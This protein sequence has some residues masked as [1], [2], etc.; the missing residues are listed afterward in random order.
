M[1]IPY[2]F[3]GIPNGE[4]IPLNYLDDNFTY[5][6]TQ[7]DSIQSGPTGPTGAASTVPGP[8]GPTGRNGPTGP[9]GPT[10]SAGPVGSSGATGPTGPT[11]DI[12]PTGSIGVT[13]PT[14]QPG[15]GVLYK[16]VVTTTGTLPTG[17]NTEGD[18]YIV[19]D[20]DH[21]WVWDGA[22]WTD[23]GPVTVGVTGPT[24]P[25]GSTGN[26]GPTGAGGPTGV[27]GPT[28]NS[29]PTGPTGTGPTG[30]TGAAGPTGSA[31][32]AAGPTGPTGDAGTVGP[33]GPAGPTNIVR[34][35]TIASLRLSPVSTTVTPL[36]TGYYADGDGGGGEYYG[37]TGKASGFFVDNG[38]TIIVPTGG[39]G[40]SAWLLIGTSSTT[41]LY[42]EQINVLCFGADPTGVNS[43]SSAF[44]AA[45]AAGTN[46]LIPAGSYKLSTNVTFSSN[47]QFLQGATLNIQTSVT[48]TFNSGIV[49]GSYKIFNPSSWTSSFVVFNEEK[50]IIGYPEWWGAVVGGTDCTNAINACIVACP[51]TQLGNGQY[52]V[53]STIVIRKQGRTLQGTSMGGYTNVYGPTFGGA[54]PGYPDYSSQICTTS[55][56]ITIVALGLASAPT[57]LDQQLISDICLKNVTINRLIAP[58]VGSDTPGVFVQGTLSCTIESVDSWNSIVGFAFT[59]NLITYVY[60]CFSPRT[61]AGTGGTDKFIGFKLYPTNSLTNA[62]IYLTD[63][64]AGVWPNITV[65]KSNSTGYYIQSPCND[66]FFLRVAAGTLNTGVRLLGESDNNV[67]IMF[68]DCILDNMYQ[69]GFHLTGIP[70]NGAVSIK[71]CYIALAGSNANVMGLRLTNCNGV[72]LTNNQVIGGTS[73]ST[74][75][76]GLYLAP[77]TVTSTSQTTNMITSIG[78][79]WLDCTYGVYM[80]SASLCRIEDVCVNVSYNSN[81][82]AV[83]LD[84]QTNRCYIA[85]IVGGNSGYWGYGVLAGA[86]SSYNEINR[87]T[88]SPTAATTRTSN[89]GSAN[90]INGT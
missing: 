81:E 32:T 45:N 73:T 70:G 75:K 60:K 57:A 83:T 53:T 66:C 6:E 56:T 23:G 3:G 40:S 54:A 69:Y 7:I 74:T 10:G 9:T 89:S 48:V 58:T 22:A 5:L 4:T 72:M 18:A 52:Y 24:G 38:G 59:A 17:G 82:P 67:D 31:S 41:K 13:G 50:Q 44:I 30:P 36:V 26:A 42:D 34:Y 71:G 35:T 28:G 27:S 65:Q 90:Q 88:I 55:S 2:T 25:T 33:T 86:S 84:Y 80:A 19:Q 11:G 64:S 1:P 8:T 14:G 87:T 61:L 76:F 63:C 20:D 78:N 47:V 37:V 15:S 68:T 29:G 49:A 85:P 46:V 62:S 79:R 51:V 39:N 21:L 16:G 77:T 12:G 43:S